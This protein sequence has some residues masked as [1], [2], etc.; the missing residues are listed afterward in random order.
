VTGT[1]RKSNVNIEDH[2]MKK[3]L[4]IV[5]VVAMSASPALADVTA[6]YGAS[7]NPLSGWTSTTVSYTNTVNPSHSRTDYTSTGMSIFTKTFQTAGEN[8]QLG[9]TFYAFCVDLNQT[10][11]WGETNTYSLVNPANI[12]QPADN[13]DQPM[14]AAK[15]N[16]LTHFF[17]AYYS[18]LFDGI[19]DF[20]D[21]AAFQLAVWEI[22]YEDSGS[23]NMSTGNLKATG[24]ALARA[25]ELLGGSWQ[26]SSTNLSLVGLSHI[27]TG[28]LGGDG[29]D[30]VTVVPAPGAAVLIGLGLSVIGWLKRRIA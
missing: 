22:V 30:F 26:D 15:A 25:N 1:S 28:Q 8:P 5:A 17:S 2:K 11:S 23:Y 24:T 29:Q 20:N 19:S 3:Y 6:T 14:G 4:G 12:P 13:P 18:S 10:V 16:L 9:S 7:S 21:R 27:P